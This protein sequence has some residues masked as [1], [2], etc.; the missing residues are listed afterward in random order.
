ME[1]S[2]EASG[3]ESAGLED[4]VRHWQAIGPKA[5][6]LLV[7]LAERLAIGNGR[8]GDFELGRD[9]TTEAGEEL[10]D[11]TI[12][13]AARALQQKAARLS[14]T[15]YVPR[16]GDFVRIS[17]VW[18]NDPKPEH[19]V[20]FTFMLRSFEPADGCCGAGEGW[21]VAENTICRLEPVK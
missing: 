10:L 18:P 21:Y 4:L 1:G 13:L 7:A 11:G 16:S 20:G 3:A 5:R 12:Y 15:S 19:D 8:H 2:S 17:Q 6:R 14:E 9:W